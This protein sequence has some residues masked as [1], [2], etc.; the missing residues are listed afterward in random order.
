MNK[1]QLEASKY[2]VRLLTGHLRQQGESIDAAIAS[3]DFEAAVAMVDPLVSV[4]IILVR[5]L[6]TALGRDVPSALRSA[7]EFARPELDECWVVAGQVI[8]EII[9]GNAPSSVERGPRVVGIGAQEIARG[10]AN[11]LAKLRGEHPNAVVARLRKQLREQG[12]AVQLSD[13]ESVEAKM[14]EYA[15]DPVMRRSRIDVAS[16]LV[17][18]INQAAVVLHNRGVDLHEQGEIESRDCYEGACRVAVTAAALGAGVIQLIG[19]NNHYPAYA[20]I[21]QI[22]ETEFVL[23]KFQHDPSLVDAWLNSDR[24]SREQGW[25][26]SRIYRDDDNDYRQ[27]DYSGHCEM[28]GHPTPTGTLIAAGERSDIAEASVVGDL[29][30]HL[31]DSWKHILGVANALDVKYSQPSASIDTELE[32]KV[33]VALDSWA[34]TDKYGFSTTYFSDPID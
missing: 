6:K 20:L 30:L 15:S 22:V 19:V 34:K 31:R 13:K 21:R 16:V 2:G 24:E 4:A 1:V 8:E 12:E 26:P 25:K 5:Q 17:R 14:E 23:W 7:H 27:K 32:T 28:G 33:R 11:A 3:G 9:A 10:A 18:A 29:I